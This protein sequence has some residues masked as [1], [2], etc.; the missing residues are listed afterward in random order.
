[1][2]DKNSLEVLE[3]EW[4]SGV[5]LNP[6]EVI[7]KAVKN[8]NPLSH[9]KRKNDHQYALSIC[10][11]IAELFL[12]C[13]DY[14]ASHQDESIRKIEKIF[15]IAMFLYLYTEAPACEQTLCMVCELV[16]A[17]NPSDSE[18]FSSDLDRLFSL[19]EEKN[20]EHLALTQYKIYQKS[21]VARQIALRSVKK[22][23]RPLI[24]ISL[25][26]EKSIFSEY[27]GN[28]ELFELAA[29]LVH[30]CGDLPEE[31]QAIYKMIDEIIF[32][33]VALAY[34]MWEFDVADQTHH[35]LFEILENPKT[36]AMEI[37]FALKSAPPEAFPE[38]QG[39]FAY[40]YKHCLREIYNDNFK[41]AKL[42]DIVKF[43]GEYK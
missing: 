8:K 17:D 26:Y 15:L 3:K 24:S 4:R 9:L 7:N 6:F 41:N 34:M 5:L 32:V 18:N 35:D 14:L 23:F 30:N 29:S 43:Y 12:D 13:T 2:I 38:L 42:N 22:R 27:C 25:S 10:E 21:G 16:T 33:T 11:E 37:S 40:W 39:E 28:F 20:D 36:H 1:M 31:P 19:L